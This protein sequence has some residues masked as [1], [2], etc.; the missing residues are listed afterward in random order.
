MTVNHN[1][2]IGKNVLLSKMC[3]SF[4]IYLK[5]SRGAG[6]NMRKTGK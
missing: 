3:Y 4:R 1:M 6:K 2:F 5:K